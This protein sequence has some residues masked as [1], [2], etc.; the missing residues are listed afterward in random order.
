MSSQ[1]KQM[2][3][4]KSKLEKVV[5]AN[6]SAI[7]VVAIV[8]NKINAL[9]S[10]FLGFWA[11]QAVIISL[12]VGLF[13]LTV[14]L[15]KRTLHQNGKRLAES[16]SELVD[17]VQD[18]KSASNSLAESSTKQAANLEVTAASIEE[19]SS[20]AQHTAENA[21]QGA[22]Y[23]REVKGLLEKAS[24]NM[25]EVLNII[26]EIKVASEETGQIIKTIDD[27]AFQT[28]LLALNAA[29]E[30]ARAGEFG[31]GFAV[32]AE[33]VRSLALRSAQ[34]SSEIAKKLNVSRDLSDDSVNATNKLSVVLNSIQEAVN[35]TAI[36][37][38]E[39]SAASKE[40]SVG[41][42]QTASALADI[43][44]ITQ[45]NSAASQE[46]STK[47]Q[48]LNKLIGVGLD[49]LKLVF[50]EAVKTSSG[51]GS[52]VELPEHTMKP[53]NSQ[54]AIKVDVVDDDFFLTTNKSAE[55]TDFSRL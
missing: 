26:R 9:L 7:T 10:T 25:V 30:A 6:L 20:M 23:M 4:F 11:A 47:V 12:V 39:I 33:E 15:I 21:S 40:Q 37:I 17:H 46:L 2:T 18:L 34:A 45:A 31:K 44:K 27:I 14:W 55:E 3:L 38:D 36:L 35:K 32:V 24:S 5:I 53:P 13:A 22:S 8:S 50:G 48:D 42:S 28:N 1:K 43:D 19:V 54:K 51:S 16:F 49:S 41:I 52:L 29:V